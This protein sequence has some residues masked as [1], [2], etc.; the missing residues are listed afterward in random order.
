MG[1]GGSRLRPKHLKECS[2]SNISTGVVVTV[3]CNSSCILKQNVPLHT[4]TV[5]IWMHVVRALLWL[6]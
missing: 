6:L 2:I 1:L 5:S 4:E 3:F